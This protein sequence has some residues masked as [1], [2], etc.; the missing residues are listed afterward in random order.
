MGLQAAGNPTAPVYCLW[1]P[2]GGAVTGAAPVIGEETEAVCEHDSAGEL[3]ELEAAP[4]EPSSRAGA[5]RGRL[6]PSFLLLWAPSLW[7]SASSVFFTCPL[8]SSR[9]P[10]PAMLPAT[11]WPTL[12]PWMRTFGLCPRACLPCESPSEQVPP[13][14]TPAERMGVF[15]GCSSWGDWVFSSFP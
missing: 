7:S 9:V 6:L 15:L 5:L 12:V 4:S 13:V 11:G 2:E 10:A 8:T 3:A 14:S 1:D